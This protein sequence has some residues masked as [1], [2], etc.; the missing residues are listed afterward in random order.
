MSRTN[1]ACPAWARNYRRAE[2]SVGFDVVGRNRFLNEYDRNYSKDLF[3][4]FN[5]A[6]RGYDTRET[7][8]SGRW[9]RRHAKRCVS[10]IIRARGKTEIRAALNDKD[11]A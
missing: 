2:K 6:P 9:C 4:A 7:T 11:D 3:Q 8:S 10:R 5:G 1:R